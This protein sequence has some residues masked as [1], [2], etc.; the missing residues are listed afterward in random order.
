[1]KPVQCAPPKPAPRGAHA[2]ESAKRSL[3]DVAPAK[4]PCGGKVERQSD[5]AWEASIGAPSGDAT[6]WKQTVPAPKGRVEPAGQE[7]VADCAVESVEKGDVSGTESASSGCREEATPAAK[8]SPE[9]VPS[10]EKEEKKE[11]CRCSGDKTSREVRRWA[12]PLEERL[13][14]E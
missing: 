6:D 14:L 3:I 8:E 2:E 5:S 12:S 9:A 7:E 1:M 10:V 13:I 4:W 11:G